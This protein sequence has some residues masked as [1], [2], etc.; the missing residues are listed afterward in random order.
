MGKTLL[1]DNLPEDEIESFVDWINHNND[2]VLQISDSF[3][4]IEPLSIS[5]PALPR[6]T[7]EEL[8][9]D[10]LGLNPLNGTLRQPRRSYSISRPFSVRAMTG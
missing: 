8:Q 6:P 1:V 4:T 9:R 7:L 3:N 2:R 5:I 10:S